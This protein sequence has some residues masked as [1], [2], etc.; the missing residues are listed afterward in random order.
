MIQSMGNI[1]VIYS[2]YRDHVSMLSRLLFFVNVWY[3]LLFEINFI[4][5]AKYGSN[6]MVSIY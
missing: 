5:A 1:Q 3:Y 4:N 6:T 2:I